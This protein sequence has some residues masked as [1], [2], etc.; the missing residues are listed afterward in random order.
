MSQP[1]ADELNTNAARAEIFDRI[2]TLQGRPDSFR[3]SEHLQA[4]AY[5][6]R[7]ERG[8]GP[9]AVADVV[10]LF[11][12]RS[13]S[14]LCT[15]ARLV[16]MD[17]APKACASYMAEHQ[18]QG[19]PAVW[20]SLANLDWQAAGLNVRVGA[21]HGD[22]LIAISGVAYAV[23]ETGTLVFASRPDEPAS[24]HLLPETH[25]A[26]VRNDQVVH[27]MEDAFARLR[28]EGR[29]MPRALNFVSGPSRTADIEQTIVL[30]AH[31]PYRVHLVLVG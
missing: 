6:G 12:E 11:V 27:T 21:P 18:L 4:N 3:A 19:T 5:M 28:T 1:P 10:S 16:S 15:V 23:A 29:A 2:R 17:D 26:L 20:P 30:G 14:M 31:G 8:P 22:D 25:I 13:K 7:H 9:S 24:T